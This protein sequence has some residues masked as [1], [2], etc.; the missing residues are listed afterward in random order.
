MLM[1]VGKCRVRDWVFRLYAQS[2][3]Y[4]HRLRDEVLPHGFALM[5]DVF[6][7]SVMHRARAAIEGILGMST[8]SSPYGNAALWPP[9]Q[10]RG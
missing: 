5:G 10:R 1:G 6:G 9:Q 8:S 7:Q 4:C 2:L 3:K